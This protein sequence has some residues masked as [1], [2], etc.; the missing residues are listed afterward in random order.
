VEVNGRGLVQ[1]V[2]PPMIQQLNNMEII[3]PVEH[4]TLL[5]PW[6]ETAF[7]SLQKTLIERISKELG[8]LFVDIA[9]PSNL[10]Q[11]V[12]KITSN[13]EEQANTLKRDFPYPCADGAFN[14]FISNMSA[15]LHLVQLSNRD[16]QEIID[17]KVE[18]RASATDRTSKFGSKSK[19]NYLIVK[20]TKEETE[21]HRFYKLE[22]RTCFK[23]CNGT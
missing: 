17:E 4:C 22:T 16:S 3:Q 21:H 10:D 12:H 2:L 7:S 5:T 11:R 13:M 14:S 19:N 18:Q 15:Q 6:S 1:K 8:K 20:R 9:D 23:H